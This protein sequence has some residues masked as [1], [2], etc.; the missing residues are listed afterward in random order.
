MELWSGTLHSSD[1]PE[2]GY[3]WFS[4]QHSCN[5]SETNGTMDFPTGTLPPLGFANDNA[6]GSTIIDWST[7]QQ[8]KHTISPVV[9]TARPSGFKYLAVGRLRSVWTASMILVYNRFS[10]VTSNSTTSFHVARMIYLLLQTSGILLINDSVQLW[11][12]TAR[13]GPQQTSVKIYSTI[14]IKWWPTTPRGGNMIGIWSHGYDALPINYFE[15]WTI[16]E[17][18]LEPVTFEPLRYSSDLHGFT[19]YTLY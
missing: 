3:Q 9:S 15:F 14:D 2:I 17:G 13:L 19:L 1:F 4:Q 11:S 5:W 6:L 8:R 12:N 7:N 18:S 16:H 10:A